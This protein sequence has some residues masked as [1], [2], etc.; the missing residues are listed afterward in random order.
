[1]FALFTS[2][3]MQHTIK[4]TY[5]QTYQQTPPQQKLKSRNH[6]GQETQRDGNSANDQRPS[7]KDSRRGRESPLPK[8]KHWP[9]GGPVRFEPRIPY[10]GTRN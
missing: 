2:A 8:P 1:M 10:N 3:D 4:H 5:R 9:T 7:P 6:T